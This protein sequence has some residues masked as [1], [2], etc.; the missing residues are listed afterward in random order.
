MTIWPENLKGSVYQVQWLSSIGVISNWGDN[1]W[2][3]NISLTFTLTKWP[4]N[5][6]GLSTFYG[7]PLYQSHLLSNKMVTS[8]HRTWKKEW[9]SSHTPRSNIAWECCIQWMAIQSIRD[10]QSDKK[11]DINCSSKGSNQHFL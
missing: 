6:S 7:Q 11:G 8:Q 4:E 3:N 2:T 10:G 5:Q 9:A 1:I